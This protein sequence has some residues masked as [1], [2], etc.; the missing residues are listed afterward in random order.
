MIDPDEGAWIAV[1]G[2][3]LT[4]GVFFDMVA[5]L[6]GSSTTSGPTVPSHPGHSANYS[7][8]C[9]L[10]ERRP[11]QGRLKCGAF[12]YQIRLSS[13]AQRAG[14][15]RRANVVSRQAGDLQLSFRLKT[16]VWEPSF[17]EVWFAELLAWPRLPSVLLLGF[18]MWDMQY[19]PA[20]DPEAGVAAFGSALD[21]FLTRLQQ[22]LRM[23][24]REL[25]A[26]Q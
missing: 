12:V 15:V 19:P 10:M 1:Y 17:D 11:P 18:G 16:F 5:S 26:T 23:K 24:L 25:G 22:A 2:D 6:N 4:R 13:D 9:F 7:E 20:N 21:T 3:S 14:Q 8:G